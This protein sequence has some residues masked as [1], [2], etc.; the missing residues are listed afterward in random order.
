MR[1]FA[2]V[3][4]NRRIVINAL[5]VSLVMGTLLKAINQGCQFLN[6]LKVAW[7]QVLLNFMVPYGVAPYRAAKNEAER[8]INGN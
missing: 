5:H 2:R 8:N 4:V 3:L 7:A 6:S 1:G